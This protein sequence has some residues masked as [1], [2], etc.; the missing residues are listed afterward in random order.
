MLVGL[1]FAGWYSLSDDPKE[2]HILYARIEAVEKGLSA[3]NQPY[4]ND[5]VRYLRDTVLETLNYEGFKRIDGLIRR[6]NSIYDLFSRY[7]I[8]DIAPSNNNKGAIVK[9]SKANFAFEQYQS[10]FS[11]NEW[12]GLKQCSDQTQKDALMIRTADMAGIAAMKVV[13]LEEKIQ[14]KEETAQRVV[15]NLQEQ[16]K[17]DRETAQ[18]IVTNLQEKNRTLEERIA[19]LEV[20]TKKDREEK[21]RQLINE[22]KQVQESKEP[23]EEKK[24]Q[25]G[26]FITTGRRELGNFKFGIRW[27]YNGEIVKLEG[28]NIEAEGKGEFSWGPLKIIGSF[29]HNRLDLSNAIIK[30]E[31]IEVPIN[32]VGYFNLENIKKISGRS[33]DKEKQ[34]ITANMP[35][36]S[37]YIFSP[38]LIQFV[39]KDGQISEFVAER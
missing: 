12:A 31:D 28:D 14:K 11:Q 32:S 6:K 34:Q 1:L 4:F 13:E 39:T 20:S 25:E 5:V 23:T 17:K 30:R 38:N 16:M 7:E 3:N 9:A 29:S 2:Q 35:D 8:E 24:Q 18:E 27:K 19:A 26:S 22:P 21:E 15:N 10:M 37:K 36:G 33:G